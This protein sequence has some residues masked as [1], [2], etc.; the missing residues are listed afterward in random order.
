MQSLPLLGLALNYTPFGIRLSPI[1]IVL[2][3]FTISLA[4]CAYARRSR[5]PEADRFSVDLGTLFESIKESFKANDTKLDRILS[6]IL[7]IAIVLAI[8]MTVYAI[9]TPKEGE[10][11]TEFYTRRA[12]ENQKLEFLLYKNPFRK[13]VYGEE[14]KEEP[15][16][17]LH[18]WVNVKG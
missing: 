14:G 1:L 13:S 12:G 3:A 9:I 18:L 17:A 8:S 5:I 7:V 11:F 6:V 4:L 15:Y 2:S 10:K 16:R